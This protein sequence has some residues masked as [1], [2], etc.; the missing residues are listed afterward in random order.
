MTKKINVL[1]HKNGRESAMLL[2]CIGSMN[3]GKTS[4]S[5][6]DVEGYINMKSAY[7]PATSK[8]HCL[9]KDETEPNTYHISEDGGKT[10]TL[11]IEWV[12]VFS[13]DDVSK[14]LN[15]MPENDEE[16]EFELWRSEKY[17]KSTYPGLWLAKDC[18]YPLLDDKKLR[19]LF[20]DQKV[21]S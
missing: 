18:D 7:L 3:E 20:N 14:P 1:I 6:R 9:I 12:E 13:I 10:F 2:D 4:F 8:G 15:G 19:D 21:I 5:P 11:S 17:K 16:I